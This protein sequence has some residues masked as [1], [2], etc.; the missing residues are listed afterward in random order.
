MRILNLLNGK[1][2]LPFVFHECTFF[3]LNVSNVCPSPD[4]SGSPEKKQLDGSAAVVATPEAHR[5]ATE[6]SWFFEDYSERRD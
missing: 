3:P 5:S 4:C 2:V 6:G 1:V